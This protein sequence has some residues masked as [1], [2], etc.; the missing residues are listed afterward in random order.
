MRKFITLLGIFLFIPQLLLAQGG[1]TGIIPT[2]PSVNRTNWSYVGYGANISGAS[3][4]GILIDGVRNGV[5][6]IVSTSVSGAGAITVDLGAVRAISRL[7]LRLWDGDNR[8]Y[9]YSVQHSQDNLSYEVLVDRTTGEHQS[10]QHLEFSPVAARYVKITGTYVST[11]N[12]FRLIDEVILSGESNVTPH[13]EE[14]LSIDPLV[15]GNESSGVQ[16]TLHAGI[17]EVSYEGGAASRWPTDSANSGKTWSIDLTAKA[18]LFDAQYDFGLPAEKFARFATAPLAAAYGQNKRFTI[19]LPYESVVAFYFSDSNPGD[20]RGGLEYRIRQ[21]SGPSDSLLARVRDAL[22]RSTLWEERAVAGWGSW[23]NSSNRDCFGCHIQTQASVGLNDSKQKLPDLPISLELEA[24]FVDAYQYWLNSTGIVTSNSGFPRTS[25]A[26][27]AWAVS[28]FK[29]PSLEQVTPD[30]VL[31]MN[32]L[33]SNQQANGGWNSDHADGNAQRLYYDGVPS[34]AL[35]TGNMQALSTLIS[36]LGASVP[37]YQ[38]SLELA[39][40]LYIAPTWSYTRNVRTA[41]QTIIG[42]FGA[43]P[44]LNSSMTQQAVTRLQEIGVALRAAQRADGGWSDAMDGSGSSGPYYTAMALKALSLIADSTLDE[45]LRRGADYLL[46]SQNGSGYWQQSG[47]GQSLAPTTWVEIALP[48]IFDVLNQQY[49]RDVITDLTA[50][51]FVGEN[52][53]YWSPI[54]GASGYD[55]YRKVEGAPLQRIAS[56]YVNGVV[57]YLDTNV[58]NEV[59]YYYMVKW[60]DN[61]G[62]ESAESNEASATPYGLQCGADTPPVIRSGAPVS[63]IPEEQYLY[64]VDATDPDVGDILSYALDVAPTGMVI[65]PG[66]RV[67]WTPSQQQVGSH[68]VKVRVS[69]RIGRFATQAYRINVSEVYFNREPEFYTVP[70]TTAYQGNPYQYVARAADPNVGDMLTYTLLEKPAGATINPTTGR[71]NWSPST[72]QNGISHF[73][74]VRVT[75]TGGLFDEQE[76]N[77]LVSGNTAP[78][79]TSTPGSVVYTG[80]VYFYDVEASDAEGGA[81]LYALTQAPAGMYINP[82]SGAIVWTSGGAGSALVR[83]QVRDAA[84][85]VAEQAFTLEVVNNLPPIITSV[86]PAQGVVGEPYGYEITATDPELNPITYGLV[87]G[88][89]GMTLSG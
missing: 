68:F 48:A 43:L 16:R 70:T 33:I 31:G 4:A 6:T 64:Q 36:S 10:V 42:L 50:E 67:T 17:Y 25:T 13:A 2:D 8:Y 56:G 24:E 57:T 53:L 19:H 29:G 34:A 71:I 45:E 69:D 78:V 55:I 22:T 28:S 52:R 23:L 39:V 7:Q 21:L 84:G 27:W 15:H 66:G 9:R 26:L 77:V 62:R 11:G 80:Q 18:K 40:Q 49:E 3:N 1:L 79:I 32:W 65:S 35:T 37:T 85:A 73:F 54:E 82:S 74:K 46:E 72:A 30:L 59:T 58:T 47:F 88:P 38:S 44:H 61:E 60:L 86:P 81:L 63:A 20:N 51:G 41:S 89:S 5:G 14:V 87:S 83:V 12:E 75:D 76:F